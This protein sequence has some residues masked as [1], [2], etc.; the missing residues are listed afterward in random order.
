MTTSGWR[1]PWPNWCGASSHEEYDLGRMAV[2][3]SWVY[4]ERVTSAIVVAGMPE[5]VVEL[6]N[7]ALVGELTVIARNGHLRTDPLI[8]LWAGRYILIRS[9]ILF[10]RKL[11]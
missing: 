10:S 7:K 11:E 9:S 2:L 5:A 4:H 3:G 1:T 8:P 6:L